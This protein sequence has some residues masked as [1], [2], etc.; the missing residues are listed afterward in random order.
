MSRRTVKDDFS[1]P[2]LPP[3]TWPEREAAWR[4]RERHLL[5]DRAAAWEQL[6]EE[7]ERADQAEAE[8]RKLTAEL[9]R[10]KKRIAE[11]ESAH[12]AAAAAAADTSPGP[13]TLPAFVKPNVAKKARKRPGRKAGHA[14]ALRPMP[15]KVDQVEDVPLATDAGGRELCPR[16]RGVLAALK[17]HERLVEDLT[18][19]NLL[20]TKFTT[21]SGHCVNCDRRVESRAPHQPPAAD[22]PHGQIG[23]NALALGVMLRIRHRLPFRQIRTVLEKMAGLLVSA[24]GLVKQLKR[25]ARWLRGEYEQLILRMR[26]SGVI[27]ADETGWRIDGKNAWAWVFTQP[28]LTLFVVDA[29]RGRDVVKDALGEAFGGRLVCD[30]YGAYDGVDCDKQRCLTHLLR[31]LKDLGEK[32][33]S[34]AADEWAMKLKQWCKSA[35]AHKK[36]WKTLSD[37]KYELGASRLEDQLD[38]LVKLNPAHAEAKRLHKRVKKYRPELTRFLWHEHLEPTNNPAE[39]ALRPLVVA[40][41]VSGGSRSVSATEAWAQLSSLL[42]TQEQNGRNVLEETKKLLMDYWATG[43]R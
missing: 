22:V 7:T 28:L 37:P 42:A 35:I 25:I 2:P 20:V 6:T 8:V 32:D 24:G 14:A 43:E 38:A 13:P 11:L 23:L 40:R 4:D 21:H 39:R 5:L 26:A 30:F 29:S 1:P 3:M 34:F 41:K 10:A 9:T 27:H 15:A 12:R 17:S 31:E 19:S 18:P 16:C 36:K 33:E